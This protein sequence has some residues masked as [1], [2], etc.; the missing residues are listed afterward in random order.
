MVP[1]YVSEEQNNQ[2]SQDNEEFGPFQSNTQVLSETAAATTATASATTP[3]A[4][5]AGDE[6]AADFKTSQNTMSAP[7]VRN[8]SSSEGRNASQTKITLG[9]YVKFFGNLLDKDHCNYRPVPT[10]GSQDNQQETVALGETAL[11]R[12]DDLCGG[13]A[14]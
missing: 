5:V 9:D 2:G 3:S 4:T 11:G 14:K 1:K 13:L 6:T 12:E 8:P 10:E 7:H